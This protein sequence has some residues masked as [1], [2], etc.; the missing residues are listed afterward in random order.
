MPNPKVGTVTDDV[1][2]AVGESKAGKVE[3]RTDRQAI[4][5]LAIGKT[6]F[7]ERAPARELRRGDRGDRPRQAGRLQGP[8]PDLDHPDDDDGPR[9]SA[10]TP[11][12]RPSA[13]SSPA[14]S[15][16]G[17]GRRGAGSGLVFAARLS[18]IR[19]AQSAA[20]SRRRSSRRSAPWRAALA[21]AVIDG[22]APLP[23]SPRRPR[24][25]R[26]PPSRATPA[27]PRH[28]I[29]PTIAPQNP[30]MAREPEQQH[31]QRHL[32]D[33]RLP[34]HGPA[35]PLAA[36]PTRR[37]SR[38]RSAARS[39]STAAAGSSASAR[40]RSPRR[41]PG[42]S[43]PTRWRR[44]PAYDLPDRPRPARH[45]DLPE[46]HRRRLLLPRQPR[47]DLGRR[48]RPT[49]SSS[50]RESADGQSLVKV[51]DYD[52]TGGPRREHRADH[53]GAARL[54]RPD[55]VRLEEERQGRHARPQDR[56]RSA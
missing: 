38:R 22:S 51:R 18:R 1:E 6:S 36:S 37:R 53:L 15:R 19:E 39:P 34:A 8:L 46:L 45:Q 26:C 32:D 44:S 31:P 5:H 42:S 52:L 7:E 55:L 14:G 35:R 2:K 11:R 41:R 30:F 54:P 16:G 25:P 48:P 47:P 13:R 21:M 49:T 29:K 43:T 20:R 23:R 50:S 40:R 56:R 24:R 28:R 4:I 10:S 17:R 3:Y 9:R 33:R 27:R 12:R